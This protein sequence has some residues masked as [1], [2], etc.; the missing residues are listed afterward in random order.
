VTLFLG[1]DGVK[2][3][4]GACRDETCE[5]NLSNLFVHSRVVLRRC[6]NGN[7]F[8]FKMSERRLL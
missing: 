7:D 4:Y 2:F 8:S 3:Y 6:R 1:F 5:N